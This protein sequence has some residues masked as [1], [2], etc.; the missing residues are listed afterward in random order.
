MFLLRFNCRKNLPRHTLGRRKDRVARHGQLARQSP[1]DDPMI[2]FMMR[3]AGVSVDTRDIEL[4]SM[5]EVT[6]AT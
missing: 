1:A 4:I 6:A 2:A 5:I 3:A